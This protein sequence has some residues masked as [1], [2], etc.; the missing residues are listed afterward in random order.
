[1][2][3]NLD[4]ESERMRKRIMDKLKSRTYHKKFCVSCGKYLAS[5]AN[6]LKYQCFDCWRAKNPPPPK[7]NKQLLN[8]LIDEIVNHD[9]DEEMDIIFVPFDDWAEEE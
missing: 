8:D 3:N 1:M 5:M 2:K 6:N 9:P 7:P 4:A